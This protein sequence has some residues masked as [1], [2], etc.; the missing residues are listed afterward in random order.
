MAKNNFG[1]KLFRAKM[2]GQIIW[3]PIK[4]RSTGNNFSI[5]PKWSS[6]L[7]LPNGPEKNDPKL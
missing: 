3:R 4:I 7:V 6:I 1:Q 5:V 2:I